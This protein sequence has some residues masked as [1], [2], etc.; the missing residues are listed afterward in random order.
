MHTVDIYEVWH[1]YW[2]ALMFSY[3]GGTLNVQWG[4]SCTYKKSVVVILTQDVYVLKKTINGVVRYAKHS[5]HIDLIIVLALTLILTL[6][7][8]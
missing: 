7:L 6:T 2:Y 4:M 5:F 8:K 1:L 3:G